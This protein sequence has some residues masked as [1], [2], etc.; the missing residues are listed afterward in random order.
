[1]R[2]LAAVVAV[3]ALAPCAAAAG[4]FT[5]SDPQ[6]DAIW[7]AS[8]RTAH[9]MISPP[10]R[11]LPGCGVPPHETVILDGVV[12]D[13]CEY[14]G[15]IAV[16]GMTLYAADG[17][18]RSPVRDV[19]LLFARKQHRDGLVPE[20][21]G[22]RTYGLVDYTG[23]WVEDV[24]DYVLYSGDL[25]TARTLWPHVVRALD[26]WYPA[27]MRNGLM[28]D[29]LPPRADYAGVDRKDR[30][31]AYYNAQAVRVLGLGAALARWLHEDGATRRWST[32]AAALARRADAA[33]WDAKASA[34]K[35]SL[36][37]P[38]VHPQDGNAF[39]VLAGVADHARAVSALNYL[40][41]HERYGYGNSIA[42]NDDWSGGAWGDHAGERVYPFMS[43]YEV[44]ARFATGLDASALDLI[45]REW[46]YML[47]N[48]PESTMWETIGPFGG[49]PVNH[50]WDHGWSSGAAPA[51]TAYVLGVQPTSPGFETFTVTP[52]YDPG[53]WWARGDVPSPRGMIHVSWHF[54]AD[55]KLVADVAAPPGTKWVRRS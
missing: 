37:G 20:F 9:D 6:L 21:P 38:L 39:A 45:R 1:M 23:Y 41:A 30:Y 4:S 40:D 3:L 52:H 15:D 7:S 33:F 53:V 28:A 19:L 43:Y 49:G 22:A 11:L 42:D 24:Y 51:L 13:R 44:L 26:V 55:G 2:T 46:G 31:V 47:A 10:V 54:D 35:D 14:T 18:S 5:S 48:G 16:T 25:R 8:V 29:L 34:Y 36:H 27:Q 17:A 12:R 32:R 50:S